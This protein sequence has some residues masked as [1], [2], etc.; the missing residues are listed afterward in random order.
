VHLIVR[1]YLS[2]IVA[3]EEQSV[4]H[5]VVCACSLRYAAYNAHAQY[6]IANYELPGN[7]IFFTS[8]HKG[9]EF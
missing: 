4:L 3:V 8:S 1:G 9:Q 5:T 2:T 7:N 6:Y